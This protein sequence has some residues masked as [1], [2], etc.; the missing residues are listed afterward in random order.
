MP[1]GTL[2]PG[3]F[4]ISFH[5]LESKKERRIATGGWCRI[6]VGSTRI[7]RVLRFNASLPCDSKKSTGGI[8]LDYDVWLELSGFAEVV[9][10]SL[11]I[12]ITKARPYEY[13]YCVLKHPDPSYRLSGWLGVIS[14]VLGLIGVALGLLSLLPK[15]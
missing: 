11:D 12:L 15:T 6:S 7:F 4:A 5:W 13:I 9:P 8:V 2:S 10:E 3:W 1:G 14:I